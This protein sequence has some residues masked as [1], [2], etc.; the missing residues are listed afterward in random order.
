VNVVA[1]TRPDFRLILVREYRHGRGEVVTG[2]VSGT[3]ENIGPEGAPEAAETAARRELLEET[4]YRGGQFQQILV[5]YPNPANQNNKVTSF[6]A[7]DVGPSG[8]R[9]L[10]PNEEIEVVVADF[11]EVLT[12]L[13][14][15]TL[16]MQ[17]MHVAAL[18]SAA[19]SIAGGQSALPIEPLR[20]RLVAVLTSNYSKSS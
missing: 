3:V 2:L 15:G 13:R 17:A 10:D 16:R 14:A 1:L 8:Q 12:S 5:S 7:F 19:A 4:G 11:V 9:S 20:R 18:W 6:I